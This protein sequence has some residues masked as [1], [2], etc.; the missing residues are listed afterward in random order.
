MCQPGWRAAAAMCGE[1][2]RCLL[3]SPVEKIQITALFVCF[4]LENCCSQMHVLPKS[5]DT[6]M[7][8]LRAE[9]YFSV[10]REGL[11][12]K[13][14]EVTGLEFRLQ[15]YTDLKISKPIL[16]FL[17]Q[18]RKHGCIYFTVHRAVFCQWVKTHPPITHRVSKPSLCPA[19]SPGGVWGR[20]AVRC[21][22]VM[23]GHAGQKL[24][25]WWRGGQAC[26][27]L[28]FFIDAQ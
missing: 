14:G 10:V 8:W 18:S 11:W 16:K 22:W 4:S 19:F 2:S 1:L 17:Y 5:D 25:Q 27:K 24:P 7:V 28:C 23:V 21:S 13:S 26:C 12:R 3:D 15:L 20:A 6:N 9:G